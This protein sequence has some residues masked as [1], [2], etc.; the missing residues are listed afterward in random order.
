VWE[1]EERLEVVLP[2]EV[3][4]THVPSVHVSLYGHNCVALTGPHVRLSLSIA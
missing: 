4:L 2:E 1:C 3:N